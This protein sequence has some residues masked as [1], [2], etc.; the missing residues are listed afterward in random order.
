[1]VRIYYK[2]GRQVMK[3][4]DVRQLGILKH[5][6][7]VDLHSPSQEEEEWVETKS[8]ISIQTPQEISEIESSSRFI[9]RNQE[10]TANSIFLHFHNEQIHQHPVSFI[11][12]D[13]VLYTYRNAEQMTF[14]DAVRKIK[15]NNDA[16]QSG[17]DVLLCL[18]E[19]R[20]DLDADMIERIAREITIASRKLGIENT[21]N[22]KLLI[23]ISNL[24]ENTMM[25][26]ESVIDKQ[27]VLSNMLRSDHFPGEKKERLRIILKDI[28]SLIEYTTFNFER[29]EYLQ[30]TFT[31]LINLD[32]NRIIKR[33]TVFSIAFLPPTLL[34]G[35]FGM[36]FDKIPWARHDWGFFFSILLMGLSSLLVLIIFK[37][38][39]WI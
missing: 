15:V 6:I 29:L 19:T 34:A 32:Q 16:F 25:I 37:R 11:L 39:G 21:P 38:K 22:E 4:T 12:K 26:R 35:M 10:I 33:F 3:D 28:S 27:R 36:N 14:G 8:N 30:D 5:I 20:I 1:M 31:G 2:E 23:E 17:V 18:L 24:Q 13:D 7:W 9:E